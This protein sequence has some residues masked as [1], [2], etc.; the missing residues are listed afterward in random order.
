MGNF[1]NEAECRP[2][3]LRAKVSSRKHFANEADLVG[4]FFSFCWHVESLE[5]YFRGWNKVSRGWFI[6]ESFF[7]NSFRHLLI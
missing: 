7:E 3:N 1:S 5:N 6:V 2:R 4:I